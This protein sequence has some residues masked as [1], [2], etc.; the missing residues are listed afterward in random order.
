MAAVVSRYRALYKGRATPWK[1]MYRKRCVAR[2]KKSRTKLL[3]RYR[4]VGNDQGCNLRESFLVQEVMEEEWK[5]LDTHLPSLWKEGS[6]P[7]VLN[8]LENISELAELEEIEQ[9]LLNEEKAII[10]E[11]EASLHFDDACMNAIVEGFDDPD[12]LVCPVCNRNYLSISSDSVTCSCGMCI[13][14]Q[15]V[16][17]QLFRALIEHNVTEHSSL[18]GCCPV[19]SV[20]YGKETEAM[21]L[22]SCQACDFLSVIL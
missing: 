3:E 5:A 18:C 22:M 20:I 17:V 16:T 12:R 6:L 8:T 21:L 9:E 4:H 19:F 14:S 11:Y 13:N 10:E 7:E 2:L 1:E 15:G